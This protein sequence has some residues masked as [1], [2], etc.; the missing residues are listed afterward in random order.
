[1]L[2]EQDIIRRLQQATSHIGVTGIGDDAAVIPLNETESYV[3][4][5]DLLVEDLHFSLAYFD[6]E[7]LAHKALHVNLSDIAAMGTLPCY[8]LLGI[9]IPSL[10]SEKFLHSFLDHFSRLCQKNNVHLIGGDTTASSGKLIISLT[11]IGRAVTS[12]LKFRNRAQPNEL[13]A[14]A[15]NMGYAHL[16]LKALEEGMSDFEAFTST[17]LRPMARVKEGLWFGAQSAVSSMID[18]SDG[19]HIDLSRLCTAS[20]VGSEILVNSLI[21][22]SEFLD[23]CIRLHLDPL[24]SMLIGGEDYGLLV[25]LKA[26]EYES[27][28]HRF[29]E[30]FGYQ[31][32]L[33]GKTTDTGVV[34]LMK[35][36]R[37]I[38]FVY[39]AFSH[40]GE[41]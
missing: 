2:D 3:I 13:I 7:S 28:A 26:D 20:K 37:E 5:K 14:V 29:E 41:L 17:S 31:L 22:S 21:P 27:I 18:L 40:F 35:N 12:Q 32:T 24:E 36:N 9:A 15:G 33:I 8:V 30:L 16:G 34:K 1:M 39:R 4:T 19:L 23:A 10:L 6:P 25:T 38:P 11:V